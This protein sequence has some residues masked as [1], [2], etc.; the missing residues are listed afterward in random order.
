MRASHRGLRQEECRAIER[1]DTSV[2]LRAESSLAE[3]YTRLLR[4]A[5]ALTSVEDARVLPTTEQVVAGTPGDAHVPLLLFRLLQFAVLPK[6]LGESAGGALYLAGKR[7]A[8]ELGLKSV[9]AVEDWFGGVQLGDL[10][11]DLDDDRVIAKIEQCASCHFVTATGTPICDLSRGIVDGALESLLQRP[12]VTRETQ[13]CAMGDTVCQFEGYASPEG[14]VYAEDG[15][16]PALRRRLMRQIADQAEVAADN[17]RLLSERKAHETNDPLT[18]LMNF[19]VLRERA[20]HELARAERYQKNVTFVMID[21]DD[22]QVL[23]EEYGREAGDEVLRHWAAALT[24]Q[25]RNCDLICRYGADEFLLVLPET[26]DM[27]AASVL[28]RVLGTMRTFRIP[29]NGESVIVSASVGVA[30]YPEDGQTADE[31]VARATTTMY[32][33]RAGGKGRIAYYSRF[34]RA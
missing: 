4:N 17:M 8:V 23:N 26:G 12:V 18:G 28:E 27:Q 34:R 22:F 24:A 29:I 1:H 13:C 7:F 33:A 9:H 6:V 3:D 25:I 21:L 10:E 14:Y 31:F 5:L 32:T 19:R 11:I 15:F 30:N 2:L 20:V 16:H